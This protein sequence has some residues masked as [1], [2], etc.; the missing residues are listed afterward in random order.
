MP[1][2]C[3]LFCNQKSIT[4]KKKLRNRIYEWIVHHFQCLFIFCYSTKHI[5][6]SLVYI[7][8]K[9]YVLTFVYNKCTQTETQVAVEN[10]FFAFS[11]RKYTIGQPSGK[12]YG[13]ALAG[14]HRPQTVLCILY[15]FESVFLLNHCEIIYY[16]W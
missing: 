16:I 3:F 1:V 14:V 8:K 12:I 5:H 11:Q 6:R 13:I 4:Q 9:V 15:N 7:K 2:V 10:F